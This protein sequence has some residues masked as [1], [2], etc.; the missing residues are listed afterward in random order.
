MMHDE[1]DDLERDEIASRYGLRGGRRRRRR[2]EA[3]ERSGPGPF[4]RSP[5]R[6]TFPPV[7]PLLALLLGGAV[8][9]TASGLLPTAGAGDG[10]LLRVERISVSGQHRV[11]AAEIAAATGV[12]PGS[13]LLGLDVPAVEARL[14]Q[15]PWIAEAHAVRLPPARLLVA[16]RERVP[17]AWSHAAGEPAGTPFLLDAGG[18]PFAPAAPADQSALPELTSAEPLQPGTPVPG[19]AVARDALRAFSA[20]TLPPVRE[21]ALPRGP[22]DPL[23]V[24]LRDVAPALWLDA[25]DLP[26][27]ILRLQKLLTVALP[28]TAAAASIDL[29]FSDQAVLRGE[30]SPRGGE[31]EAA[32][33]GGPPQ[34][35]GP[36]G[37]RRPSKGG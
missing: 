9:L 19:F 32:R 1:D 16:V 28:E 34:A 4:R 24:R 33:E 25:G 13:A 6:I 35:T 3:E 14:R 29:R 37:F 20:A 22:G 2:A 31:T 17:V 26:D 11:P 15:H 5:G 21:I 18:L 10:P 23:R 8:L 27:E 30:T 12:A 7:L 36:A